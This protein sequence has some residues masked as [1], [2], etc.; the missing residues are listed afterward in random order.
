MQLMKSKQVITIILLLALCLEPSVYVNAK[1]IKSHM[2]EFSQS[3][4]KVIIGYR[5]KTKTKT[6]K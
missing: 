2:T 1:E 5:T 6:K 3:K 4:T